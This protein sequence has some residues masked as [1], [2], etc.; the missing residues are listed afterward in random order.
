MEKNMSEQKH[1]REPLTSD[2]LIGFFTIA[3]IIIGTIVILVGL[4]NLHTD[5]IVPGLVL[6]AVLILA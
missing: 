2:T 3:G 4:F 1:K 5:G 6:S